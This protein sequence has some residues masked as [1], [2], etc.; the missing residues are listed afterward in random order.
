[1]TPKDQL[2]ASN[3]EFRKLAQEHTQYAQRLET[4]TVKRYLTEDE[5]LE[6]VRLKKLKLRLKDQM[7]SIERQL[8]LVL[9]HGQVA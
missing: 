6:E 1:M 9:Q 7:E 8:R 2:L 4:L 5:K 3:E